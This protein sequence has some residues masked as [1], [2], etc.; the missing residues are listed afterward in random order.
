MWGDLRKSNQALGKMGRATSI[1]TIQAI[2]GRHVAK[3]APAA[4]T[5]AREPDKSPATG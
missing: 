2:R 5:A 4:T 1:E 3:M